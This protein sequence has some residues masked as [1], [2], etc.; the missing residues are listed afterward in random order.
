MVLALVGMKEVEQDVERQEEYYIGIDLD[1]QWAQISYVT[2]KM[3][4]PQTVSLV[5][6]EEQYRIPTALYRPYG[7]GSWYL[8]GPGKKISGEEGWYIDGLWEKSLKKETVKVPQECDGE[9]LLLLFLRKVIR[10]VPGLSDMEK[11][12]AVTFHLKE[13]N[14]LSVEL[15]R[16]IS[17]RMGLEETRVFIQD[18]AES[19]CHFAMNQEAGLMQH[20]MVLFACEEHQLSC[21]YLTKEMRTSPRKVQIKSYDLGTLPEERKERDDAFAKKAESILHGKIASA[22]YLVGA[23]L[24]GDWLEES[25]Q[26][27]CR[28]RRAFQGK[29]LYT[30]GA[31]YGSYMQMHREQGDYVYFSDHKL[32][33]NVFI[34]VKNEDRQFF[35]DLAEAGSSCYEVSMSCQVLL[36]GE[37]SVDVWL[38]APDSHNARVE[39]LLLTDLPKRPPKATRLKIEILPSEKQKIMIRITDLGFGA[40]YPPSG[41]VWE[42]C[43]NE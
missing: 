33:N 35:L 14:L 34:Q 4:E 21:Y 13:V 7:S 38:Q 41:K 40:W 16:R 27:L 2:S 31:C 9:E 28:G 12:E 36:D 20:D 30:K 39:S 43:I 1:G 32:A 23:G 25:V 24:D 42:Y 22:V 8:Q 3:A 29:N 18:D 26:V 6:G 37:A 17:F 11:I 5:A 10:L 19:F 15:L